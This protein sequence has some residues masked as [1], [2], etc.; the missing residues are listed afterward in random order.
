MTPRN[1]NNNNNNKNENDDYRC[2]FRAHT[3]ALKKGPSGGSTQQKKSED[4]KPEEE[5]SSRDSKATDT[6]TDD[7]VSSVKNVNDIADKL[8]E[9]HK[10]L[11]PR[12]REYSEAEKQQVQ[13]L[14]DEKKS[15]MEE[16]DRIEKDGKAE[17]DAIALAEKA[18]ASEEERKQ[19]E[20]EKK[21]KEKKLAD[22]LKDISETVYAV[23]KDLAQHDS[24]DY[25]AIIKER[26]DIEQKKKNKILEQAELDKKKGDINEQLDFDQIDLVE[27]RSAANDDV[28]K[29]DDE[30]KTLSSDDEKEEKERAKKE[31]LAKLKTDLAEKMNRI[32]EL[33]SKLAE[34]NK[35]NILPPKE[36]GEMYAPQ[37]VNDV[38]LDD[39]KL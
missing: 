39:I 7:D 24:D 32:N 19:K 20:I 23:E 38:S 21:F 18:A 9:L 34:L 17:I 10:K 30:E 35:K 26:D 5:K 28:K 3:Q 14:E 29:L 8:A 15:I 4:K 37:D 27:L 2:R 16:R 1:N 22:D 6:E 36:D 11:K 25:E 33:K 12:T 13:D 31:V